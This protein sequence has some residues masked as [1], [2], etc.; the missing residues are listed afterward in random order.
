MNFVDDDFEMRKKCVE[1]LK[2][3]LN[4]I[5][6]LNVL[7]QTGK[8]IQNILIQVTDDMNKDGDNEE[9]NRMLVY[10]S[11]I[12]NP[13]ILNSSQRSSI[14]NLNR[15]NKNNI[16]NCNSNNSSNNNIDN[17]NN[18]IDN[19]GE[20]KMNQLFWEQAIYLCYS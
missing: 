14:N 17:N 4:E 11:E 8:E 7:H 6:F 10:L 13:I 20:I 1:N 3:T 18:S 9:F 2:C 15:K 5:Q 19:K 16:S 12:D